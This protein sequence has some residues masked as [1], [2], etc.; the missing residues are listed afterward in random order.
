MLLSK[1]YHKIFARN[2]SKKLIKKYRAQGAKIGDNCIIGADL[3]GVDICLLEIGDNVILSGEVVIL[4]HD[5]SII[6]SS[7]KKYTDILGKVKIGNNCFI[8]YRSII[9]PGVTLP[10][11]TIVAAGSVVTKSVKKEGMII[12]GNPAKIIGTVKDSFN[13][14]VKYAVNLDDTPFNSEK[15]VNKI[16]NHK[17]YLERKFMD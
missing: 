16:K 5:S 3:R 14:N 10:N 4:R 8:G 2:S 12:G 11:N 15:R 13:K 17:S 6:V 7:N 9:L 1:I